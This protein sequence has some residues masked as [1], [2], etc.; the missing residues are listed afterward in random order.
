MTSLWRNSLAF[1]LA[2]VIN[3]TVILV[4]AAFGLIEHRRERHTHLSE[5]IER[6]REQGHVL[7]VA[8]DHL[9]DPAE[10]SSYIDS[11]C[12]QMDRHVSPGH[13]IIVLSPAGRISAR[14]H[15]P[16]SPAL[17]R[18]M[19]QTSSGQWQRFFS[20]EEPYLAVAVAGRHGT[21]IIVAQSMAPIQRVLRRLALGRMAGI[22]LL[23]SLL[24]VVINLLLIRW[25]RRPVQT[26]VDGVQG[27]SSGQF[28]RR[29]PE[30]GA[31]EFRRLATGFN[32]MAWSLQQAEQQRHREM[33]T[34]RQIHLGLLPAPETP[35]HG[36]R[37]AAQ[38]LPAEMIGGDYY[39]ILSLPDGRRLIV[40]ADVVGHGVPAALISSMVKALLRQAVRH[41][42]DLPGTIELLDHELTSLIGAQ[43]F[44][45]CLSILFTPSTGHMEYINCGHEPGL[46]IGP[47][48]RPRH[49]M[50]TS[51]IPLGIQTGAERQVAHAVL[52]PGDRL[53]LWTDGLVELPDPQGRLLGR[54]R[55]C[56]WFEAHRTEGPRDAV[57]D[58][59]ARA[60]RFRGPGS[61]PDDATLVTLWRDAQG[62]S[63]PNSP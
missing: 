38:Y 13:H 18:G 56:R 20:N 5:Q 58:I 41:R 35:I 2:L 1:R 23:L 61:F 48:A 21:T 17:E 42:L 44:V 52:D 60:R 12:Q 62:L 16:G 9:P 10:F 53:Y 46:I 57:R 29:V 3:G 50:D 34:A 45:T 59:M 32:E 37:W 6:L 11:Y 63:N 4:M 8:Q 24:L 54:D 49:R 7:R 15:R 36:A 14:A 22:S 51:G 19:I 25:V 31:P 28:E 33:E 40:I 39:D 30:K 55:L 43:H 26:L 27:I 47:D